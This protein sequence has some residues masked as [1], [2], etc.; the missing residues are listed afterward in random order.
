M[1]TKLCFYANVS[2]SMSVFFFFVQVLFGEKKWPL[3]DFLFFN[4]NY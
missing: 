3:V 4:L 2:K 1:S